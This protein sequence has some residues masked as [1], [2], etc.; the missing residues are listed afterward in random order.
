MTMKKT[1]ALDWMLWL[2]KILLGSA[3]FA[4]G[5]DLFLSPND[6]N[7]GGVSGIAMML[8]HLIG[9]GSVGTATMLINLPLFILGGLKIGKKFFVGSLIGMM[10]SSVLLDAF[11][12]VPSIAVEPLVAALYGGVLCGLG[13]GTVFVS[14]ASTGGSDIVV[15]LLKMKYRNVPIGTIN[16]IFDLTVAAL[17]GIVYWDISKALYSGIAIF[18]T[19][20]IID[21]VVYRFDYSKVVLIISDYHEEITGF[22]MEKL[23]R[24]AT[25]LE[26]SGSYSG[27]PRKVIMTVVKPAQIADLKEA[28]MAID[29]KAFLVVQDAHQVLGEGFAHYS[30]E[31]L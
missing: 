5:F 17:T 6:L 25:Y 7:A 16:M 30:K 3:I 9:F 19:G 2:G 11:A 29:P 1:D 28:V 22:I 27:T 14:G 13:L 24:G 10:S 20:K 21:A 12:K 15:R 23:D 4:L 31:S 26:G 8:V 18:F